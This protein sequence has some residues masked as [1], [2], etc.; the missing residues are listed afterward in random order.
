MVMNLRHKSYDESRSTTY[1]G[2]VTSEM[3]CP[4]LDIFEEL[5]KTLAERIDKSET[6]ERGRTAEA[7]Q[8]LLTSVHHLVS[9]LWKGTQMHE[10]YQ[11]GINKRSGRYSAN[12]RYRQPGLTYRQTI[13]AYEGLLHLRLIRETKAGFLDRENLEGS[14]TKF[15]ANDELLEMLSDINEDPFKV[16]KPDLTAECIIL[17]NTVDGKRE[18][19]DYL[20]TPSVKEMRDNLRF[21]NECLCRHWADIRIKDEDFISLQERLLIDDEKQPIDFSRWALVRI[22]SNGSFEQGGRFYRGWWQQVPS[23]LRRYITISGKKTCE[24]DYSQLNPHMVYFLRDKELG[25]ED[26][27][28]RVFDGEHRPLVKEAFNAMIQASTRLTQKPRGIDL[29]DVDI[30]RQ[31]LRDAILKAHRPIEDTFFQGLGN[32]L[33][34]IDSCIAEQVMFQFTRMDYPVLPVRDGFIMHYAFGDLGELEEAMRRAFYHHF[35]KD[36]KVKGEIGE[37]MAGS[38]DGRDSDEL[39]FDEMIDGEPEYSCWNARN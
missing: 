33:Q 32:H 6:R 25:D 1:D 18:Q 3:E 16:L 22:F 4:T 5:C 19:I 30:D 36:I 28:G 24:Y 23:E 11:A 13:S 37:L 7:K 35:K 27:Y 34:Y 10:G 9:Q 17:C 29:S 26:A 2:A 38:F 21:I 31:I 14:I 39:S 20:D 15:V 8:N 12:E